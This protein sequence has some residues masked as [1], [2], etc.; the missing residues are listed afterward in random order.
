MGNITNKN[1]F[2]NLRNYLILKQKYSIQ[3]TPAVNAKI[4]KKYK[5]SKNI[6]K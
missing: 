1:E 3:N 5:S 2:K 4:N 6:K